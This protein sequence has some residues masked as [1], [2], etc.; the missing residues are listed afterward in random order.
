LTLQSQPGD[1]VGGGVTSDIIYTPANTNNYFFAS[2]NPYDRTL[3]DGPNFT[4]FTFGQFD[5]TP[6]NFT[7][8]DFSTIELGTPLTV[9]TYSDAQRSAFASAGHPGLDVSFQHRGSCVS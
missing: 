5:Q 9:G 1:F 6:D 8:L 4:E 7:S 2:A 3:P